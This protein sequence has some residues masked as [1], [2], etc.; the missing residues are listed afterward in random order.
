MTPKLFD[1][2][3]TTEL[4][5]NNTYAHPPRQPIVAHFDDPAITVMTDFN[6]N[7]PAIIAVD[8]V[9]PEALAEMKNDHVHSLLVIDSHQQVTGLIT[10]EDILGEKPVKFIQQN[11]IARHEIKVRAMMTPRSQ[12]LTFTYDE[13]LRAKIGHVIHTMNEKKQHY[14]L[15]VMNTENRQ[16]VRGIF[17]LR[18]LC[19]QL[20]IAVHDTITGAQSLVELQKI[21]KQK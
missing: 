16:T 4:A 11:Q 1:I 7:K 14:S 10:S 20:G 3:P 2:L 12:I 6:I 17:S 21:L 5:E 15:V 8:A 19:E 9:I 13:I 18:S